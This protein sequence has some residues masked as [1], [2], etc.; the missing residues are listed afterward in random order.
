MS[1]AEHAELVLSG[2]P[3]VNLLPREVSDDAAMRALRRTLI[4]VTSGVLVI[5]AVGIGAAFWYAAGS[6]LRLAS[7]QSDSTQLLQEQSEFVSVRQVQADV[8][9]AL[10]ARA[11]AGFTDIDWKAYLVAVHALLP[12]D[13]AITGVSLAASTPLSPFE[14]SEAPLQGPRVA[15]AT[16]TLSSPTLPPVPAW[17]QSMTTLPGFVDAIPGSIQLTESGSYTVTL[18]VHVNG[19]AFTNRFS[20]AADDTDATEPDAT[21]D[22]SATAPAEGN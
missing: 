12:Q 15:T 16:V 7:A 17:L 9:T 6:T 8:D 22:S 2:E 21:A 5:V 18:T 3:R 19:G 10:A 13:V 20:Q 4:V 14:Q 11:V 1:R